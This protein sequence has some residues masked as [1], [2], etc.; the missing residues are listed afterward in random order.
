MNPAIAPI[1]IGPR[2]TRLF[3]WAGLWLV[4]AGAVLSGLSCGFRKSR[5][6]HRPRR[7]IALMTQF[8]IATLLARATQHITHIQRRPRAYGPN[9][10]RHIAWRRAMASSALRQKLRAPTLLGSIAK[11]SDA[12]R[13]P[14]RYTRAIAQRIERNL[15]KI[16]RVYAPTFVVDALCAQSACCE[17]ALDSS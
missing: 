1:P 7:Q 13:H 5:R 14:E 4:W 17:L 10:H 9:A 2:L 12:L 15:S 6:L 8:V 16:V 11:L 3:A